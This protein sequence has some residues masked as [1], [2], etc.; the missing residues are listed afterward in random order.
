MGCNSVIIGDEVKDNNVVEVLTLLKQAPELFPESSELNEKRQ[1]INFLFRNL[2]LTNEKL[3][4]KLKNPF[5]KMD[6]SK[7]CSDWL[8]QMETLRTDSI[9]YDEVKFENV[10]VLI[11][12]YSASP[13]LTQMVESNR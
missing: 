13:I 7:H 3:G 11:D 10:K 5:A 2:I 8:R 6:F 4:Y 9:P 12:N 1:I